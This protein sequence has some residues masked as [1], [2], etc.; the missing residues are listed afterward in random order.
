[1]VTAPFAIHYFWRSLSLLDPGSLRKLLAPIVDRTLRVPTYVCI[2]RSAFGIDPEQALAARSVAGVSMYFLRDIEIYVAHHIRVDTLPAERCVD[3][4][5]ASAA[6]PMN[7]FPRSNLQTNEAVDGGVVANL[8]IQPVL[9]H[10][11]DEVVVVHLRPPEDRFDDHYYADCIRRERLMLIQE[12]LPEL[13]SEAR[14]NVPL[15]PV[16]PGLELDP[17]VRQAAARALRDLPPL[18][19]VRYMP[20]HPAASLGG[21]LTGTLR[22]TPGY[23][24]RLLALGRADAA[25]AIRSYQLVRDDTETA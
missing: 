7:I 11:V 16:A 20:I 8:P 12:Q 13:V 2:G 19:N 22:F 4:V 18:P 6:L 23:V 10:G 21:F 25:A 14:Q 1:L 3:T 17:L 24:R 15:D 5:I 9:N